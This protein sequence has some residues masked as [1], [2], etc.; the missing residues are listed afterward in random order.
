MGTRTPLLLLPGLLCDAA[1]WTHQIETL[2]D[3]ADIVVPDLTQDDT[4]AAAVRRLLASAPDEFALAGLSM[5][6]YLAF[7]VLRQAPDRVSRLALLNTSAR[8]D[9]QE[10]ARMRE[11]M[12]RLADVGEFKGVTPRL[13]PRL[14]HPDR[15][16]DAPLA[17]AVTAMAERV[18]REAFLRQERLLLTRPDSRHDLSLV[19]CPTVV[20]AGRQDTLTPLADSEE[21]AE[22]I[23]RAALVVIEDC[24]HLS[25]MEQPHAVSA[26]LR[27]WLQV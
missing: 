1:L 21:M 12:M 27:Y 10:K 19:H 20:I 13:L 14:L 7:E 24:G 9:P 23:P 2:A 15:L 22:K 25:S 11:E 18:G 16:N 4:T 3:V 5:G 26:V 17:A 6:G 8:P